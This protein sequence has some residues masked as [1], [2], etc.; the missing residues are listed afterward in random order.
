VELPKAVHK[1]SARGREYFYF[2]VGRGTPHAGPRI[3]LPNNPHAPEFWQAIRAAQGTPQTAASDTID[4]LIDKYMASPS[5]TGREESTQYQYLQSLKIARA[6]WG[7]LPA[8]ALRPDHVQA[9]MDELAA[10]PGKA[11]NFL[12]AMNALQKFAR[13]RKHLLHSVTE[14]V[15]P[16]VSTTGHKPWTP[17]QLRVAMEK[18]TGTIRRGILLYNYTGQ[19][20]SDVVRLGFTDIDEGGFALRQRKTKREIWCP[21]VP[22]LA[23]EMEGWERRPGPFL[24][25][26]NGRPYTA[27]LFWRHF[28]EARE[29]IPELADVTLHGLRCTAVIRLRRAGL[30]VPQ[31]SDVIGMSLATIERYCRFADRKTSGQAV[32]V[33]LTK[34]TPEERQL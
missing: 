3:R 9:M 7:S 1:V 4:A 16:Y 15:R 31:I 6:A 28:D 13:P 2:Q 10:K 23:A 27:K 34:R 12:T 29:N 5:Y 33:Q 32:L 11:N 24:L 30:A 17:E 18:L 25:Q 26:D 19:R 14:G 8:S 21:I 20:G 22:E